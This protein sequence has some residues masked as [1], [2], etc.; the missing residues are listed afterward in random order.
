MLLDMQSLGGGVSGW[1]DVRVGCVMLGLFM[2]R[3]SGA[4][5][6]MQLF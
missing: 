6:H 3:C 1:V 2:K 4:G 5:F